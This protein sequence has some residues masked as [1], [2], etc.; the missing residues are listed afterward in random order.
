MKKSIAIILGILLVVAT[1]SF[2][3]W[4]KKT[5][6]YKLKIA[7]SPVLCEASLHVAIEKGFFKQEGLDYETVSMGT[8]AKIDGVATGKI[9][10]G[11]GMVGKFVVPLSNGLP[12]KITAGMHTGC[13]Q[14][15][16][17]R[18]TGI[19][20]ISNLRGKKIGVAS[21]VDAEIVI[22]KRALA[23][24]GIDISQGSSEVEFVIFN[25]PDLP[26]ALE[27]G[28]IDAFTATDPIAAVSISEKGFKALLTT[29]TDKPF[30]DEYCCVSFVSSDVAKKYPDIAKKF[31]VAM[32]KASQWV[33]DNPKEAARMQIEKGYV[34]GALE[35]NAAAL[36]SYKYIPSVD[37]GY[38]ALLSYIKKLIDLKML[39]SSNAKNLADK[40][41]V[42][43]KL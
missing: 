39:D 28:A 9:D 19:N 16:T 34:A 25:A 35:V 37:G 5:S 3:A 14:I 23:A 38:N 12:M 21:M 2:S 30:A 36:D 20:S 17:R 4:G 10:A 32:M 24:V 33:E 41:F 31:T 18:D 42:R 8:P 7:Y 11:F 26:V 1:L 40:S 13:I 27:K 43:Y 22:T 29:A 6:N 15:V